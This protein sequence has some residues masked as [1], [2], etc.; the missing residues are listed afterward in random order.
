MTSSIIYSLHPERKNLLSLAFASPELREGTL[1]EP[2]IITTMMTVIMFPD[3]S[4][5]CAN[6]WKYVFVALKHTLPP[7][8]D[9]TLPLIFTTVWKLESV[10]VHMLPPAWWESVQ[11]FMTKRLRRSFSKQS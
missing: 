5:T 7:L 6:V 9:W 3:I 2:G 8:S 1:W 11:K 4:A 10:Y